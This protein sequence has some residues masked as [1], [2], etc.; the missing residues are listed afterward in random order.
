MQS[1]V[2]N[3]K[4]LHYHIIPSGLGLANTNCVNLIGSGTVVS[5]RSFFAELQELEEHGVVS[6][7][8]IFISDRAH[9]VLEL[10]QLVDGLEELE[11]G[12]GM[13]GTTKKGIGPT[14]STKMSRSG[15]RIAD[16]FNQENFEARVRR[17]ADA[18]QKRFGDLLKYDVE[19]EIVEFRSYRTRLRPF[20][21]DQVPL[22]QSAKAQGLE[23]LVEGANALMLDVG[24]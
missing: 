24:M 19:K 8:R 23:I 21:V 6:K 7:D 10:H 13:L 5:V 22:L 3:G 14:Y 1:I 2:S 16:I 11:L 18:F 12:A 15:I 4:T 9:V 17:L 20:I